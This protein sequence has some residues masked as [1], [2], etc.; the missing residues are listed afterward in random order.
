MK[1]PYNRYYTSSSNFEG[2]CLIALIIGFVLFLVAGI[3]GWVANLVQVFHMANDPVTGMFIF[4]C[5]AIF[6]A[7]VGAVLGWVGMF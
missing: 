1:L 3:V 4:K 2:G 5:I 6:V 7:P